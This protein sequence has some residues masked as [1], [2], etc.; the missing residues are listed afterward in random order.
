[1]DDPLY[2]SYSD[3]A[4]HKPHIEIDDVSCTFQVQSL[5]ESLLHHFLQWHYDLSYH[6]VLVLAVARNRQFSVVYIFLRVFAEYP[7]NLYGTWLREDRLMIHNFIVD[8]DLSIYG[9]EKEYIMCFIQ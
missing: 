6:L 7:H 1:M 4:W 3:A 9:I 5:S 2:Q 8:I